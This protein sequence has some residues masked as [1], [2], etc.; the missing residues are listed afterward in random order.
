[1][2]T[3]LHWLTRSRGKATVLDLG[4]TD[5]IPRYWLACYDWSEAD[6]D[7]YDRDKEPPCPV[8]C[9]DPQTPMVAISFIRLSWNHGF[10]PSCVRNSEY[11]TRATA[12]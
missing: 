12:N 9:L 10:E 1:M 4:L 7:R 3:R 6:K 8:W 2:A 11:S 5:A